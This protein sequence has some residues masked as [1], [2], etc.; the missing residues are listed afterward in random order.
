MNNSIPEGT[1]NTSSRNRIWSN[2]KKALAEAYYSPAS[3][4]IGRVYISIA[5]VPATVATTIATGTFAHMYALAEDRTRFINAHNL[6]LSAP[7]RTGPLVGTIGGAVVTLMSAGVAL[8]IATGQG[9]P[10]LSRRAIA[11]LAASARRSFNTTAWIIT[12]IGQ[13]VRS[14]PAKVSSSALLE[15]A[16]GD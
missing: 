12:K 4:P 1:D 16:G 2:F 3:S 10:E 7:D 14:R 5:L 11:K 8:E 15:F 6:P 9:L 13:A